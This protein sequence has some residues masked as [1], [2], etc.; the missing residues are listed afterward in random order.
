MRQ[1][2]ACEICET[3][4]QFWASIDA[5]DHYR[6][7]NCGHLFVSP[8]PFQE[9]LDACYLEGHYYDKAETERDRLVREASQRVMRLEH[10]SVRFGLPR[11][12]LDVGCASGYFMRSDELVK[13]A[14]E[15]SGAEV[16]SGLLEQIELVNSPFP[17]VT[18]WEVVEHTID[19]RAFFAALS[20][21]VALGGLLALSTPLANGI[22]ARLLGT[23]FPMLTPP[24][25]LSLFTRRSINLLASEFGFREVSYRS[26]SNL[27][28]KSLA[29]G[30]SKLLFRKNIEELS[31]LGRS[32]CGAAAVAVA[33]APIAIDW[34]GWGTEMEIVFRRESR[35]TLQITEG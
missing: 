20:R 5:Y 24:Q 7:G 11:R 2:V 15:Y 31:G 30:L 33:W 13:R 16:L 21:N 25:H 23:K 8:R 34:A 9:E 19:P 4:A 18:T 27:V 29:S 14:R 6:C 26:F 10:L 35:R 3:E 17:I 32:V 22:P 12:L 1:G 28:P